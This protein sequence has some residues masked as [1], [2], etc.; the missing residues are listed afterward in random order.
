MRDLD[1]VTL[2]EIDDPFSQTIRERKIVPFVE[3]QPVLGYLVGPRS[4]EYVASVN[5]EI[6]E[7]QELARRTPLPGDFIVISPIVRGGDGGDKQVLTI[8]AMIAIMVVAP[9]AGAALA[10]TFGGTAAAWSAVFSVAAGMAVNAVAQATTP[11]PRRADDSPTYGVDGAKNT[12]SEGLP[13]PLVYGQFRLAGNIIGNYTTTDEDDNQ[14]LYM[15]INCGEGPTGPPTGWRVDE[16]DPEDVDAEVIY[17]DGSDEVNL[18]SKVPYFNETITPFSQNQR[19]TTD[20]FNY[21]TQGEVDRVR[22]DF[23]APAGLYE[24]DDDGDEHSVEVI[25]QVQYRPYGSTNEADWKDLPTSQSYGTQVPVDNWLEIRR[26]IGSDR[27]GNVL[28]ETKKYVPD[29][30]E[31]VSEFITQTEV[32]GS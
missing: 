5:G 6:I 22:L 16:Q 3:G 28:Y 9:Y 23:L 8:V 31:G 7:F 4:T 29:G 30:T 17:R 32:G 26:P 12:S 27:D 18:A 21:T 25:M 1:H 13:V 11:K 24:V 15:L 20:W 19:L 14:T 2:V 10:G